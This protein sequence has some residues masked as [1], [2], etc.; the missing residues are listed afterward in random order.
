MIRTDYQE[1]NDG[2]E[3]IVDIYESIDSVREHNIITD[4][5]AHQP[6]EH[7]GSECVRNRSHR[8]VL[9]C[10]VVLCVL[11]T[12]VIV[13]PVLIYTNITEE[14]DQLLTKYTNIIEE[15]D[16]LLTKYTNI[17]EERDQLLT[18]YTN[19]TQERDQLLTNNTNLITQNTK[20]TQEN[21][22]M[23]ECLKDGW[24]YYQ[25]SKY[26]IISER[27][28]WSESRRYCRERGAD[29]IIINNKEEQDFLVRFLNEDSLWIGLSERDVEGEW[30]WKW[31]DNSTL[32]MS[33]WGSGEP[34]SSQGED[35]A[36]Y[37]SREWNTYP[38]NTNFHSICEKSCLE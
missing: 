7:K 25:F 24:I 26:V 30:K 22:R 31:V 16:Q 37:N 20:L 29:L 13:L 10:L 11:L 12:A 27:K 21:N 28:N 33:F 8:S 17:T 32:N 4:K 3:M 35:C 15:R 1:R 5:N 6:L 38:C 2:V 23:L 14:R 19:I 34:S 36:L 9:V 18:K